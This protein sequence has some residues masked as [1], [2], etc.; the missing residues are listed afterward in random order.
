MRKEDYKKALD[1]IH[2]SE[3]FK[4]KMEKQLA[5]DEHLIPEGYEDS[6]SSVEIAPKRSWFKSIAVAAA[7]VVLIGGSGAGAYHYFQNMEDAPF[8]SS[9]TTQTT[10]EPFTE[11]P[12]DV[13]Y[14]TQFGDFT[15]MSLYLTINKG[16]A[17][18]EVQRLPNS[19]VSEITEYLNSEYE[20]GESNTT[21]DMTYNFPNSIELHFS[22]GERPY[23]LTAYDNGYEDG[24]VIFS[25]DDQDSESWYREHHVY[26]G[27]FVRVAKYLIYTDLTETNVDALIGSDDPIK[28]SAQKKRAIYELFNSYRNEITYNVNMLVCDG[29]D[30]LKESDWIRLDVADFTYEIRIGNERVD[31]AYADPAAGSEFFF[32]YT[33]PKG[34]SQGIYDIITGEDVEEETTENKVDD[35]SVTMYSVEDF[36]KSLYQQI[37]AMNDDVEVRYQPPEYITAR[38]IDFPLVGD[39][40]EQI[41]ALVENME[42]EK[43]EDYE[44]CVP[45]YDSY[46]INRDIEFGVDGVVYDPHIGL[47]CR[48][49]DMGAYSQIINIFESSLKSDD[50]TLAKYMLTM[51][52]NTYS[53]LDGDYESFFE[54]ENDSID[55]PAPN[56]RGHILVSKT[57]EAENITLDDFDANSYF[58]GCKLEYARRGDKNAW[59]LSGARNEATGGENSFFDIEAISDTVFFELSTYNVHSKTSSL[60]VNGD[61]Y[62]FDFDISYDG[63]H[64]RRYKLDVDSYGTP[65]FYEVTSYGYD[66]GDRVTTRFSISNIVY[67]RE[68][69]EVPELTSEQEANLYR[70]EFKYFN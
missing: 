66:D 17:I 39:A 48:T 11:E 57:Y 6:V 21:S 30:I 20:F 22:G 31:I 67:D 9:E 53:S 43:A 2:C 70:T 29:E 40:K 36:S 10:I 25:Y 32:D 47:V 4:E 38:R 54:Y 3:E 12:T 56:G 68:G 26:W 59:V 41:L 8:E 16:E 49:K 1:G 37:H 27:A 44:P 15:E 18:M 28:L 34:L 62:S 52:E 13:V 45:F 50:F 23:T 58:K 24:P 19:C 63:T 5:G 42:W 69:F 33:I 35:K 60:T 61:V 14:N 51:P 55:K 64:G 65:R 46:H 7:A